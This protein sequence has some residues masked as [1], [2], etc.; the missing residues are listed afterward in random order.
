MPA[1]VHVPVEDEQ[2]AGLARWREGA[3]GNGGLDQF[4]LVACGRGLRSPDDC[5]AAGERESACGGAREEGAASHREREFGREVDYEDGDRGALSACWCCIVRLAWPRS[6]PRTHPGART[7]LS[8]VTRIWGP[9]WNVGESFGQAGTVRWPRSPSPRPSPLGRG[10]NVGSVSAN[11]ATQAYSADG[12]RG[13][14]SPRERA[15]VRGKGAIDRLYRVK[16]SLAPSNNLP[17]PSGIVQECPRAAPWL[18]IAAFRERSS[19][20]SPWDW[21]NCRERSP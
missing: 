20:P 5:G 3:R 8:N 7:F 14:L 9:V 13:P 19:P 6:S 12:L 10:R 21:R 18:M 1:V 4:A 11:R 16:T 15:G 2:L 17:I